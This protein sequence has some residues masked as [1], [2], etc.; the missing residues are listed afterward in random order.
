MT[1]KPVEMAAII[2]SAPPLQEL[3]LQSTDWYSD[4]VK[5]GYFTVTNFLDFYP[6]KV[7]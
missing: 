6:Q 7:V 5:S 2:T 1:L 4:V 3:L